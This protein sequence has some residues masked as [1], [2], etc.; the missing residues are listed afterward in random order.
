MAITK[1]N[2]ISAPFV[3]SKTE[4]SERKDGSRYIGGDMVS[5]HHG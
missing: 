5:F 1:K 2:S 4:P 3:D